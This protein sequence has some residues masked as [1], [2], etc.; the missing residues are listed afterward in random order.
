MQEK[1]KR[2]Q[3]EKLKSDIAVLKKLVSEKKYPE[4]L[5]RADD[6]VVEYFASADLAR[7][8]EF[9]RSQQAEIERE[10]AVQKA[11]DEGQALLKGNR[12]EEAER[13]IQAGLEADSVNRDLLSRRERVGT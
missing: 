8:I 12:F 5:A 2:A 9:A 4:V 10:L 7:L 3:A 6:L 11:L 1:E 13:A